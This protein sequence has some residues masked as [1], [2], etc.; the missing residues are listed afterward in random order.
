MEAYRR[1]IIIL[2]ALAVAVPVVMKGRPSGQSPSPTA[3]LTLTSARPLV[4]VSGDVRHPGIYQISAN[5]VTGSVIMLAGP[6]GS[7]KTC[8]P[9]G[10]ELLQPGSGSDIRVAMNP[11]GSVAITIGAIPVVQRIVL[12]IPLEINLM[13]ADDFDRIPGIGPVLA[14]KIVG[15]RQINGGIMRPQDLLKIDGIGKYKY[16]HLKKYF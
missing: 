7:L 15:Y 12:G 3:F 5:A 8:V 14:K 9:R 6:C 2:L 10:I 1:F 11:D 4:S 16:D 13:N